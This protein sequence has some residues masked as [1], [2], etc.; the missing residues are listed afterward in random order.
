[1]A[2]TI[3]QGTSYEHPIVS[4]NTGY[5]SKD[6]TK[7]SDP[8]L[9]VRNN[10]QIAQGRYTGLRESALV[11]GVVTINT[12]N[13]INERCQY[14]Q[15]EGFVGSSGRGQV[16]GR[17]RLREA[18]DFVSHGSVTASN[19]TIGA[20][21]V[22]IGTGYRFGTVASNPTGI[23]YTLSNSSFSSPGGTLICAALIRT[24]DLPHYINDEWYLG[25]LNNGNFE[26]YYQSPVNATRIAQYAAA[27]YDMSKH[28]CAW[29]NGG[30]D[31][32]QMPI[33]N[34]N[35]PLYAMTT[36]TPSIAGSWTSLQY[37]AWLCGVQ[38]SSNATLTLMGTERTTAGRAQVGATIV[39]DG[40]GA[41]TET[42]IVPQVGFAQGS[43]AFHGPGFYTALFTDTAGATSIQAI[44]GNAN[45]NAHTAA[46]S[47][48]VE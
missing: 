20:M 33:M 2:E 45:Q 14:V 21:L 40:A 8:G 31:I 41:I 6:T 16:T 44:T 36:T 47:Q 23:S 15:P 32:V 28:F 5:K 3:D 12:N 35:G 19:T 37:S 27:S 29:R 26:V 34:A 18:Y 24:N 43:D 4:Q 30:R 48:V 1:M 9:A 22:Q 13:L 42:A 38:N 7:I 10:G 25:V 17:Y 11:D 39:I 46:T